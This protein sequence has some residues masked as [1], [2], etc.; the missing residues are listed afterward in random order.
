M[1]DRHPSELR[2]ASLVTW[3]THRYMVAS[4]PDSFSELACWPF[5][6]CYSFEL[7]VIQCCCL[8]SDWQ[9]Y[10]FDKQRFP[11]SGKFVV[12]LVKKRWL[13]QVYFT[14]SAVR[15]ASDSVLEWVLCDLWWEACPWNRSTQ[16]MCHVKKK[17]H[18]FMWRLTQPLCLPSLV[19]AQESCACLR[20]RALE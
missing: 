14:V 6:Y 1:R 5:S 12:M 7:H 17:L 15:S 2:W 3:D 11:S 16:G 19:F 8:V 9:K 13:C 4:N 18:S 20:S 10:T